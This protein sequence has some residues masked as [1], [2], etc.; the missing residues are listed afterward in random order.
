MALDTTPEAAE[1]RRTALAALNGS[2]RLQQALELSQ[3][4]AEF[5]SA[6]TLTRASA[7]RQEESGPLNESTRPA[8]P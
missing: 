6:G 5:R 3:F 4:V 1:F 7:S 8:R 2:E